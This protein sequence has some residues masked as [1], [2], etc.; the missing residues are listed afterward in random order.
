VAE[1]VTYR[2]EVFHF[3]GSTTQPSEILELRVSQGRAVRASEGANYGWPTVSSAVV[4][5]YL[6][7]T[8]PK[9]GAVSAFD[10]ALTWTAPAGVT[11]TS[12]YLFG[13]DFAT[14]T[15]TEGETA[16]Q[17]LRTR[18]DALATSFGATTA[19]ANGF[20]SLASGTSLSPWS[21]TVGPNPNPR[22]VQS[23]PS[24]VPL[25]DSTNDYREIG[26]FTRDL[27]GLGRNTSWYWDR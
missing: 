27:N 2:V 1:G 4:D 15:N 19:T 10:P 9:A 24:V 3:G 7:P 5:A 13:Q 20:A 18:L 12:G 23:A 11:V 14:V 8:A 16:G 6:R 22:C 17:A 21:A 26:V 25:T